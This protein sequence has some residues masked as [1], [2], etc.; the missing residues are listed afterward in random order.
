MWSTGTQDP[1][2]KILIFPDFMKKKPF[3]A[4]QTSLMHCIFAVRVIH[5]G[6]NGVRYLKLHQ[7]FWVC[8]ASL[9][10]FILYNLWKKYKKNPNTASKPETTTVHEIC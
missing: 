3:Q 9:E 1:P 4:C 8:F 10:L 5:M 6:I 7:Q 2:G